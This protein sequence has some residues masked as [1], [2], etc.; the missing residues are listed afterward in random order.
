LKRD[1]VKTLTKTIAFQL[2]DKGIRVNAIAP[3][4]ITTDMLDE[5]LGLARD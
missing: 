2:A 5:L 4:L 3:G 1:G